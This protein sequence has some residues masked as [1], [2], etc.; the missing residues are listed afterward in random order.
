MGAAT[1]ATGPAGAGGTA[2]G[3]GPGRIYRVGFVMEYL[4]GHVTFAKMLQRV[5]E[6][7]P[8]V[9]AEWLL[10]EPTTGLWPATM[11][12]FSRNY[13]LRSSANARR[14]V[15]RAGRF[16]VVFLHTQTLALFSG[17]LA[18]RVPSVLSTDATPKNMDEAFPTH[19][20][21]SPPVEELKRR[22][23]GPV[24][25]RPTYTMPWSEWCARSLVDDYGA[26]PRRMHMVRPGVDL[27][28]WPA[29]PRASRGPLRVLFVGA[30]FERKGGPHL[31]A[32]LAALEA[33]WECDIV[34]KSDVPGGDRVRVHRDLGQH[35]P[36]LH[37]LFA[38]ADVFVLPT[39]G[40]A[41]PWVIIEAMASGL[42]VVSTRIGA[43][44]ELVLDGATG[45]LV[46]P[47][48]VAGLAEALKRL[49]ARPEVRLGMG[50]AARRRAEEMFDERR[51]GPQV[52]ELLK[53]AADE[54]GPARSR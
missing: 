4:V 19:R 16:D 13:T 12:P 7:D 43:V 11:F 1:A 17:L 21:Q 2:R 47:G 9:Q 24:L 45:L 44:P 53:R 42:A 48:D 14:M 33:E 40:D 50:A 41:M 10:V 54:A 31:L 30:E 51:N 3:A 15:G 22:F 8:S 5:V 52:L 49:A 39:L 23:L 46:G 35:D 38:A 20:Q 25:R 28:R 29:P 37:A 36:R 32:A 6:R 34:T 27:E 18:R 26:D